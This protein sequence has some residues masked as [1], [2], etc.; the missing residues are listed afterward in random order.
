M[1]IVKRKMIRFC[2]ESVAM[3]S[4]L[5]TITNVFLT[6]IIAKDINKEFVKFV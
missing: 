5:V 4:I 6:R 2:V 3:D 1:L